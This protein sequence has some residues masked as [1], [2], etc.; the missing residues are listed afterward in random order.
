M[1]ALS[2]Y[3]CSY[4]G[5]TFGEGCDVEISSITGLRSTP[6]TRGSDV[7]KPRLHGAYPGRTLFGERIVQ[8][9]LL[10]VG[11]GESTYAQV[12]AAFANRADPADLAPL[13]FLLPGWATPRQVFGR[14]T[15]AD[16]P[17]DTN[18]QWGKVTIPVELTCPDPLIYDTATQSPSAGLPSPTAGLGFPVGFPV[19]FGSSS[20]GSFGLVNGGNESCPA[21]FTFAGPLTWPTLRIG[22]AFLGFQ[23]SLDVGDTF[24]VDTAART[25]TLN[26]ADR[27]GTLMTGSTWLYVPSGGATVA[28]ST[29]DS[30]P[31]TGTCTATAVPTAAWGLC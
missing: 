17:V 3:Q 12:A 24:V 22:S 10:M 25:A 29:V 28:F 26:G 6:P 16:F 9:S 23:V 31:V 19:G 15:K 27:T 2:A 5:L 11:V 14:P 30:T 8:I 1:T 21:V 13:Q 20:G 4:N 18:F 7:N